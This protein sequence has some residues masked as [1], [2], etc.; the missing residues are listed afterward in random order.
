MRTCVKCGSSITTYD[1]WVN[2]PDG[3][4]QH[5]DCVYPTMYSPSKADPKVKELVLQ[6]LSHR[7]IRTAD[8]MVLV[9]EEAKRLLSQDKKSCDA[10]LNLKRATKPVAKGNKT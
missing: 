8:E 3:K 6:S 1:K 4:K 9:L 2:L 5:Q 10:L 7:R